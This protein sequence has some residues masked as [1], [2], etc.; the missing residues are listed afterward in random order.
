MFGSLSSFES[1]YDELRRME[2][3]M[4]QM[5]GRGS[6]PAGIRWVSRGT[7]P[8]ANVGATA[9]AVDVYLFAPGVD[10]KSVELS[11][12]QNLLVVAGMR[13]IPEDERATYYRQERFSGEF[14]RV[15]TLPDDVD[16][17]RVDA[18]YRDGVLRITVKR[19][20]SAR[21]RKIEV[22]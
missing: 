17:D 20:E 22:H 6:A 2:Q 3:E 8:A 19:R 5:S 1:L 10:P 16:P 9:D 18:S 12:Q 14:R 11:L 21:P 15:I 4:D 13:E 7:Y